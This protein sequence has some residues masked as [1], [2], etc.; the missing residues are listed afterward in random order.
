MAHNHTTLYPVESTYY[1][2]VTESSLR[3]DITADQRDW[4]PILLP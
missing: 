4:F 1:A 3:T 2:N